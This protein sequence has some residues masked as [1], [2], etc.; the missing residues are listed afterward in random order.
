MSVHRTF[1]AGALRSLARQVV[2]NAASGAWTASALGV[3]GRHEL[4]D[5]SLQFTQ[6]SEFGT[7][8]E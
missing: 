4:R 5:A 1:A 8:V 2:E 6:L 7:D 3:A